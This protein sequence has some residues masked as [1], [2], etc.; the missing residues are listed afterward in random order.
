MPGAL[1]PRGHAEL[2]TLQAVP[3]HRR[4]WFLGLLIVLVV[5]AC[6]GAVVAYTLHLQWLDKA[7]SFDMTELGKMESASTIFDRQHATFGYIYEQKREPVPIAQMP[8]GPATRGRFGRG[9]PVLHSQRQRFRAA[10]CAPRSKTC[11]PTA[12]ARAPARSP[13]SLPRNTFPLKGRTFGAQDP[14]NLRRAPHRDDAD[15]GPDHGVLPQPHLPRQ[16]AVR[17]GGGV[18]GILRQ[19]RRAT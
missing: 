3:F 18:E 14:G 5:V 7:A 6:V 4:H 11:A 17:G 1:P 19:A 9:Q 2:R 10:F 16:R 8:A 12:S 15:E 13:S